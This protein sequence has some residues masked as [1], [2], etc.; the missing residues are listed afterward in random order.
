MGQSMV[1]MNRFPRMLYYI[2]Q[3]NWVPYSIKPVVKLAHHWNRSGN[4]RVNAF[5][6]CPSV[7]LL[8]NGQISG[9]D[10]IPNSWMPA[11]VTSPAK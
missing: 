9:P 1:D 11:A 8:V 5:S 6:N 4:V 10:Q 2:Y 7:R 3:A